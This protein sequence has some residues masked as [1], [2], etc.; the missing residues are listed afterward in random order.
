MTPPREKLNIGKAV[1]VHYKK[2][3]SLLQFVSRRRKKES[4]KA[5]S[6]ALSR[7]SE[8]YHEEKERKNIELEFFLYLI[9]VLTCLFAS[10][11][12]MGSRLV[13]GPFSELT[14]Q[15]GPVNFC[16]SLYL[17][18]WCSTVC[19]FLLTY[20]SQLPQNPSHPLISTRCRRKDHIRF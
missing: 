8:T 1:L 16:L 7:Q 15:T 13:H 10:F 17:P 14:P 4:M 6:T 12:F 18:G 20:F 2:V 5:V 3:Y 9:F 11:V 19:L